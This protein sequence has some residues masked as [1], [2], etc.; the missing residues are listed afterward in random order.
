[1]TSMADERVAALESQNSKLRRHLDA[2]LA[3]E[4]TGSPHPPL[5]LRFNRMDAWPSTPSP[6][7]G[8]GRSGGGA[9][10]GG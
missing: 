2:A 7:M 3:C 4:A 8:E 5:E 1:V 10:T 6:S 9:A